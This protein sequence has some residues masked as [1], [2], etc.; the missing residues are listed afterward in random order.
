MVD[1]MKMS[2]KN[3]RYYSWDYFVS[4]K[5]KIK[6]IVYIYASVGIFL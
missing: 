5:L 2:K 4:C 6:N 3:A 1:Y